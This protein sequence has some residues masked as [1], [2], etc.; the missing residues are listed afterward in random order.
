MDVFDLIVL[1]GGPAGY[2]AAERASEGGLRTALFEMS[3]LGGVCLNE[4][5]IPTKAMLYSAKIYS[6]AAHGE[7]YGVRVERAALDHGLV[8]KR[9]NRVVKTLVS[10]VA[11]QMKAHG[12][13]VVPSRAAV[14]GRAA[15]GF[16]VEAGGGEYS[17]RRL[18]IATGSEPVVPPI[19]GVKEGL[20][21]G[22]VCTSREMLDLADVPKRLAIVGGGVIGLEL[23][24]YFNAAGSKVTVVEMLDKIAG[25]TEAEI[26][27]ILLA[28]MRKKGIEFRL[29]SK[30]EAILPGRGAQ[31]AQIAQIAPAG[32]RAPGAGRAET[33]REGAVGQAGAAGQAAAQAEIV[34][35]DKVLLCI[36]RRP[37]LAGFGLE[38]LGAAVERGAIATDSQL[39]TNIP[40]LYA[41]GDVN[42]K[43]M[44]AHTAYREAEAAVSHMLGRRDCMGYGAIPSVIYTTPEAACVGETPE[45]ARDKGLPF[46]TAKLSLRYAGRYVAEDED[47]DGLC[48][49]LADER[50]GRLIGAHIVGS[51]ASEI[52]VSAAMM[53]ESRWAASELKKLV[54]PHPTVGEILRESLFAL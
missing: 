28:N 6:G 47:G 8:L 51:Y 14:R 40:D 9:K 17:A 16:C 32:G 21:S 2:V 35:A 10:G 30:V 5:C 48:K 37:R 42:G 3:S 52:I 53:I 50:T 1:G 13:T 39:R 18:L 36:G 33:L 12:V 23:A 26:S 24:G 20:A 4:G 27:G 34:E 38:N 41:A 45:S 22:Y 31:I 49:I 54:F 11:A 44:L 46:K 7:P 15:Q 25:P 43:A 29:G 19:P